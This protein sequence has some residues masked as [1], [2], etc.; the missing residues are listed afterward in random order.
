MSDDQRNLSALPLD[1]QDVAY[2]KA[3]TNDVYAPI[4]RYLVARGWR[5]QELGSGWWWK[6]GGEEA[7][8]GGALEQQLDED[9]IDQRN[10]IPYEPQE[11][12]G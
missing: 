8:L 7:T 1:A 5:R 11:F 4:V 6:D 10:A 9:G 12:W 2:K 3:I